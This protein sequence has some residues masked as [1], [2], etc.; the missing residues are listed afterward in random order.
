[1]AGQRNV[2]TKHKAFIAGLVEAKWT[3]GEIA[4]VLGITRGAVLL[5]RRRLGL[6]TTYRGRTR[7]ALQCRPQRRFEESLKPLNGHQPA[8]RRTPLDVLIARE[9]ISM[10]LDWLGSVG[11]RTRSIVFLR[12]QGRTL[13]DIGTRF[14]LSRER[15]R[16]ICAHT[17]MG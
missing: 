3:D 7:A 5:A 1:M 4:D 15:V 13:A 8:D 11:E 2:T 12:S 10:L 6:A 17:R 14:G 16:Q 9:E